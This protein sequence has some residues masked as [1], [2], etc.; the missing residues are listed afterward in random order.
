MT[1]LIRI[2]LYGEYVMARKSIEIDT[3]V[4]FV[5]SQV[6]DINFP[7]LTQSIPCYLNSRRIYSF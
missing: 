7:K 2:Q 3:L 6:N 1:G 5:Y 4:D